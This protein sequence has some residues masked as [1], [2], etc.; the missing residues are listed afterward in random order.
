MEVITASL[1][2]RTMELG[3]TCIIYLNV[4]QEKT[5]VSQG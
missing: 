5:H 4:T 1:D 3:S 2:Q